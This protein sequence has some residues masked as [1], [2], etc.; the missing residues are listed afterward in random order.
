MIEAE[1]DLTDNHKNNLKYQFSEE[2]KR[3]AARNIFNFFFFQK[4][5]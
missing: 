2:K 1:L 3:H 5:T 4:T